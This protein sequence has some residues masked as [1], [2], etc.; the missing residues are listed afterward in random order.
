MSHLERDID[1]RL[2]SLSDA[3]TIEWQIR[4]VIDDHRRARH[5]VQGEKDTRHEQDHEGVERDLTEHEGPVIREDLVHEGAS[6]LGNTEAI[7]EL[8]ERLTDLAV[9]AFGSLP[10]PRVGG[11]GGV[12]HV[13]VR[14]QKPGPTGWS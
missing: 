12:T 14:S 6:A 10:G 1:R 2:E 5:K 3:L 7:V 11:D 4:T 9:G 13:V 8:V